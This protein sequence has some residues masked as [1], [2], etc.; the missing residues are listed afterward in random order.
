MYWYTGKDEPVAT[1]TTPTDVVRT[2]EAESETDT[3][4]TV[5]E[6]DAPDADDGNTYSATAQYLTPAREPHDVTVDLTVT[7]GIVTDVTVLYDGSKNYANQHQERFD[8][9]IA[10]AVV[11]VS[12]ADVTADRVGGASLTSGAFNDAVADIR[13][14]A[15]TS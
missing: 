2:P 13:N 10:D 8:V 5:D 4:P 6:N 12:L 1:D 7:D 11:G 9:E 14:E 3:E 15:G